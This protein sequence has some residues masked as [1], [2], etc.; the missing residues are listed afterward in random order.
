M[1]CRLPSRRA[2]ALAVLFCH[3]TAALFSAA[4]VKLPRRA[5]PADTLSSATTARDATQPPLPANDC[6]TPDA[7]PCALAPRVNI[8]LATRA[9]LTRLP[10]VG[11]GLAARI[12]A[13][14]ERYGA[15]RRAEHLLMVRGFGERRFARLRDLITVE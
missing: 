13:H 5:Q 11:D 6:A 15:F 12:V 14:R 10:G 2:P 7:K 8:N 9:E 4:C 3:A 1:F